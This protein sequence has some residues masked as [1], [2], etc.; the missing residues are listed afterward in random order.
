MSHREPIK[1][2]V[3]G[4][5]EKGQAVLVDETP[6][7]HKQ[8]LDDGTTFA[9]IWSTDQAPADNSDPRDGA[10]PPVFSGKSHNPNGG[11]VLRIVDIAPLSPSPMHRTTS[12]DY[13]IILSGHC[14]LELDGGEKRLLGPHDICVQRGTN[15]I[16]RNLSETEWCRIAFVLL[17]AKPLQINGQALGD[18]NFP[19]GP[20]DN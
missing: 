20:K 10:K 17:E 4:H 7:P 5:N 12:I 6:I 1:R 11:S 8:I 9:L 15:H 14:E 3:T 13:G 16:W 18:E 2:F 19:E